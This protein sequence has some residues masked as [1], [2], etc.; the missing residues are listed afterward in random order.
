LS[1]HPF[2]NLPDGRAVTE[3]RLALPCGMSA[4]ILDYGAILRDL[5]VPARNGEPR[6][7]V[8]GFRE[9]KGYVEDGAYLGA[10]AGRHANRIA[11]GRF[12]LDG[13]TCRLTRNERG[14]THLHGGHAG[15]SRKLW[16]ILAHDAASLSLGLTSPAGEEGYPGTLEAR[17]VYRLLPPTTL[18]IELT[19]ATDA[20]TIVNLAHHSYFTLSHG[21][22]IRRHRLALDAA[23]YT[24]VDGDLIPTGEIRSVAGTP[25]DFR[26]ARA[27]ADPT[28][29]GDFAYDINFALASAG[30]SL[31]RAARLSV[32]DGP[33]GIE[34][35][36]TEPGLQLYEGSNLAAGHPGL[37]GR[38]HFPHAGLCLEPGR[39]PDGPNHAGFP[40]PVLR[41]GETY[42]Q[43]TEY[44]FVEAGA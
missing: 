14:R 21:D 10:L 19:A 2:G 41:P 8:L 29:G 24:P 25:Y 38:P 34:L 42:R 39:F 32:P 18:Q 22:S 28:V 36:T 5:L 13:K 31:A 7:V 40:S 44:R 15:F 4:S 33:L 27:L 20:P 30:G 26:A 35:Y 16:R 17:C 3:A 11:G 43:V 1:L 37:D 6:R 12:P 23:R 9:L